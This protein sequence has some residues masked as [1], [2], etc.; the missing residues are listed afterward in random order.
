MEPLTKRFDG[1]VFQPYLELLKSGYRFHRAFDHARHCWSQGLTHSEL[2]NGPFLERA[3]TYAPGEALDVLG[4]HDRTV[5]T[6]RQRI[7]GRSLYCHQTS[8]LRLVLQN[9]NAIIATGTSSGKTLC[10]QVPILDDLVRDPATG[11]RAVIIYP[12][13]ALVNDQLNEWEQILRAHPKITFARFTGQTPDS[14]ETYE[15]SLRIQIHQESLEKQPQITQA[16]RQQWER[17]ELDRHL[18]EAPQNRLN[19]REAIRRNPP[20]PLTRPSSM[21]H[22]SSFL[23]SMKSTHIAAFS[24]PKSLF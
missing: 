18:K 14:Q 7:G 17:K 22:D 15:N 12:L 3:L 4:L 13:N 10:Y 2:V 8:A 23:F 6:I 16:E 19:H 20:N 5:A 9:K 11:L 24:P 1:E 21:P